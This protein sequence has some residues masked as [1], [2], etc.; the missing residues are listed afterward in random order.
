MRRPGN[1]LRLPLSVLGT[2]CQLVEEAQH[3]DRQ[4]RW[5]LRMVLLGR[6]WRIL[7][8]TFVQRDAPAVPALPRPVASTQLRVAAP[9]VSSLHSG[10][11]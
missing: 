10:V 2:V 8:F 7:L 9:E 6:I 3:G 5:K 11:V 4:E 1:E